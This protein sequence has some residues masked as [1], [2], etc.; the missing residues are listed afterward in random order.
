MYHRTASEVSHLLDTTLPSSVS[1][2]T[3][4]GPAG[5]QPRKTTRRL[6]WAC[7]SHPRYSLLLMSLHRRPDRRLHL[8][9]L[10]APLSHL[11]SSC[12]WHLPWVPPSAA[13]LLPDGLSLKAVQAP[14]L[15]LHCR[16]P[17]FHRHEPAVRLPPKRVESNLQTVG[18]LHFPT[19]ERGLDLETTAEQK[20]CTRHSLG[21]IFSTHDDQ[22]APCIASG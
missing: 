9:G 12:L 14:P 15:L 21:Q 7:H 3:T 16:C 8:H 1:L 22:C 13:L 6:S 4:I 18:L 19:I 10:P 5:H 20:E 2:A 17:L 11:S